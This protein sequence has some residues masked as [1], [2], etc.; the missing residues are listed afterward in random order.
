MYKVV[1]GSDDGLEA[2]MLHQPAVRVEDHEEDRL[3]LI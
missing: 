3:V 1:R 2:N